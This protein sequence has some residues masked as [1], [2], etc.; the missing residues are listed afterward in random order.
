MTIAS[1]LETV[2]FEGEFANT[3]F[4]KNLFLY[5][6]KK[7]ERMW[8]VI[9]AHDCVFAM[10]SLEKKLGVGSGNLR[11]ADAS[12]LEETLG[13]KGGSVNLFSIINDKDKK[14]GLIVDHTL[15]NNFEYVGFHPM[16]NDFTTAIKKED[17]KKII[18]LSGHEAMD[19][20]FTTLEGGASEGQ[21]A[22]V[23]KPAKTESQKQPK[24]EPKK[25][26]KI[27]NAH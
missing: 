18:E 8:L 24:K 1:M 21:T 3:K 7:K 23:A 25:E 27:E 6:K 4:A 26:A 19:L 14:V 17:V 13:V 10:K 22:P 15:L 12:V 2:K 9:C 11:G 20:D 16:Q 5:D